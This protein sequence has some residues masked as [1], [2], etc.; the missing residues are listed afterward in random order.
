MSDFIRV[1]D[2]RAACRI[3]V[4]PGEREQTQE[5]RIDAELAC[6]LRPAGVSDRLEDTIDYAWVRDELVRVAEAS[7]FNLIEAL[8]ERLAAVCLTPDSVRSVRV[9]VAKP[10]AGGGNGI[11]EVELNRARLAD[12]SGMARS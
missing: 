2:V 9:C 12:Q 10:N 6:D 1:R 3:G 8:A 4:Y 7:E 11:F 5:I